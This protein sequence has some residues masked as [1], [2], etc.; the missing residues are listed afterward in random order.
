MHDKY[1]DRGLVFIAAYEEDLTMSITR[2]DFGRVGDGAPVDLYTLTNRQGLT[3]E[4]MTYGGILVALRAPDRAGRLATITLGFDTLDEYLTPHPYFGA[5]IGRYGNR[6]AGGRFDLQGRTYQLARNNGQNHLHGGVRGFDKVIWAARPHVTSGAV[7]LAL[8][9]RSPDGEEG[10]PGNLEV[11]VVYTLTDHDELRLDYL[12][13]TDQETVVNLTNHAYFNLDLRE[14]DTILEH[15]VWLLA[16]HYLPVDTTLI[17]TGERRRVRG[18]PFDFT[19]PQSIGGRLHHDDEQLQ[20]GNGG[21]DHCWLFDHEGDLSVPV[22]R[23]ME[24]RTGRLLEV[25]TT[26]PGVQF[27]TGN[28]LDGSLRD[29]TGRPYGKQAGF[30]LETQHFP[31]SPNQPDFPSTVLRPGQ[32]YQQ[33]TIYRLAVLSS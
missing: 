1:D 13:T 24:K 3:A 12:A 4:I 26:Q 6:I 8:D 15:E 22:A 16:E 9:Y 20:Y 2:R 32:T 21:Y 33:T 25:Y 19:T 29:A 7:S 17:P 5:L 11:N 30:C 18:S 14:A 10:Y 27:Y 28:M 31:N 23:V